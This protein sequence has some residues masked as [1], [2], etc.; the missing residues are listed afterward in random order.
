MPAV[1]YLVPSCLLIFHVVQ[2]T[3]RRYHPIAPLLT[4]WPQSRVIGS[5]T[6]LC[7]TY[8][9]PPRLSTRPPRTTLPPRFLTRLNHRTHRV[10]R[11]AKYLRLQLVDL[12]LAPHPAVLVTMLRVTVHVDVHVV[13]PIPRASVQRAL[14]ALVARVDV[15]HVLAGD[16]KGHLSRHIEAVA[17]TVRSPR[18]WIHHGR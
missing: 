7:C 13:G 18:K 12:V 10:V 14:Y 3:N 8:A 2:R 16:L 1:H 11:H 4:S 17:A 5:T 9:Y 6:T 15:G